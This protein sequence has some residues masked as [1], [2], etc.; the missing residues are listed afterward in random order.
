MSPLSLTLTQA[1]TVLGVQRT[2]GDR[3]GVPLSSGPS[4]AGG[5]R[6]LKQRERQQAELFPSRCGSR[7]EE[8]EGGA[9]LRWA[10]FPPLRSEGA[11]ANANRAGGHMGPPLHSA[12]ASAPAPPGAKGFATPIKQTA[13]GFPN[14]NPEAVCFMPFHRRA[15]Y[16]AGGCR[17]E[18]I[19]RRSSGSGADR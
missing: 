14:R 12:A 17:Q 18:Y 8:H 6:S 15:P 13:P 1:L 5:G 7:S 11:F 2:P 9:H 4:G 16:R 10:H 3:C 19:R